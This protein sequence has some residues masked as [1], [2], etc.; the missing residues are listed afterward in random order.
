MLILKAISVKPMHGWSIANRIALAT[1]QQLLVRQGSL[2]PALHRLEAKGY[3]TA[4]WG[5]SENNR[6]AKFY[7]LTAKGRKRLTEETGNWKQFSTAVD[8]VLQMS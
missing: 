6:K 5:P 8:L 4:E 7:G 1:N 2:Y 3:I